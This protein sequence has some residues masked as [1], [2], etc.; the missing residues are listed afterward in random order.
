M[1]MRSLLL[2]VCG[3][4]LVCGVRLAAADTQPGAGVSGPDAA[5]DAPPAA[6]T[7]SPVNAHDLAL[8]V[9]QL[10]DDDPR[11][12]DAATRTLGTMGRSALPAL[13]E[14]AKGDDPEVA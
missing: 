14:A 7:T 2:F 11:V 6:P 9:A 12:R 8:A 5:T 4:L 13:R 1:R 3:V 10:G